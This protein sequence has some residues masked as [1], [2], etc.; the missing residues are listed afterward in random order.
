RPILDYLNIHDPIT[1]IYASGI[2]IILIF[3]VRGLFSLVVLRYKATLMAAIALSLSLRLFMGYLRAP[4]SLHLVRNTAHFN[5][6]VMQE[7][8]R[9]VNGFL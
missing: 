2:A 3:I 1:F 4:Y 5:H 8:E 7:T 6:N 9:L